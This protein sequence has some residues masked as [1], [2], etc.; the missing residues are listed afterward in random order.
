MS[1]PPKENAGERRART[2]TAG[3]PPA[4]RLTTTVRTDI[5]MA[6]PTERRAVD[7]QY[8]TPNE[9]AGRRIDPVF[10]VW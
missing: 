9:L 5:S 4:L 3:G 1:C 6:C 2:E 8:S 7:G 10:A